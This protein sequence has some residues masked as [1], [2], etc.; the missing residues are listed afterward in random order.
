MPQ[1]QPE[2]LVV[3]ATI[4]AL[5]VLLF[6]LLRVL[7]RS[8]PG[9]W[10]RIWVLAGTGSMLF[11]IAEIGALAQ[12][13]TAIDV[14]HQVPLFGAILATTGCFLVA[15]VEAYQVAQHDRILALTDE[16]T[17]LANARALHE[18]LKLSYQD[19]SDSFALVYLDLDGFKRVNDQFGHER[20]DAVLRVV[21]TT[22]LETLRQS[23][24]AARLGGDEFALF[25]RGSDADNARAV[26]ER[27]LRPLRER[28]GPE[29]AG[30]HLGAS[31]GVATRREAVDQQG[32]LEAADRAMYA[33]KRGDGLRVMFSGNAA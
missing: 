10:R 31:V 19:P 29:L 7:P 15:Y 14:A 26:T 28:L 27:A 1:L 8:R 13:G 4:D 9:A 24:M 32:L 2:P 23:D 22:L 25:L 17:G 21:G 3:I 5:L 12:G 20:G 6:F 16:L 11:V 18:R 33:A 30:L